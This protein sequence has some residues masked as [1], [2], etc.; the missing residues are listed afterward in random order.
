MV[1]TVLFGI[2][3]M[4]SFSS[5]A[6][7]KYV[8]SIIIPVCFILTVKKYLTMTL[9]GRRRILFHKVD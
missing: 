9:L 1:S 7:L 6:V 2:K 5:K 4:V 3:T 8:I